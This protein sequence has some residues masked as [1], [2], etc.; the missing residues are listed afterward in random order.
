[1]SHKQQGDLG[2]AAAIA[3]YMGLGYTVCY[4]LTDTARYDLV[5]DKGTLLRVQVKTSRYQVKS[6]S[7]HVSLRTKGGNQSWSGLVKKVT[8]DECDLVFVNTGDGNYEMPVA[9]VDGMSTVTLGKKYQ[10]YKLG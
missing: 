5:V 8:A 9:V 7:Y 3:H 2:V 10:Q 4:P 6:G 1:M